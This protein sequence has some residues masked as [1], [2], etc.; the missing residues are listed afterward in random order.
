MSFANVII[1]FMNYRKAILYRS[2]GSQIDSEIVLV[3]I[4][5]AYHL[6]Q[7]ETDWF[8]KP[9]DGRSENGQ[10]KRQVNQE[11]THKHTSHTDTAV[12]SKLQY[13]AC[14]HT[15][16]ARHS[17]TAYTVLYVHVAKNPYWTVSHLPCTY[18]TSHRCVWATGKRPILPLSSPQGQTAEG[19]Q[20]PQCLR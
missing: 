13:N 17:N 2:A 6:R 20:R 1:F 11:K 16:I 7:E 15:E 4:P 10:E 12:K 5:E 19:S 8:D 9:R 18:M 14:T 3:F